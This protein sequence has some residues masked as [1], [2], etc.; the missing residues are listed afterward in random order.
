MQFEAKEKYTIQDLLQIITIL[1]SPE[2]CPWDREQTHESIRT[3]LIEE[4]YEVAD[5]IDQKDAHLLQEELGDLLLQILLHTEMERECSRFDFDDVCNTL[6]Q[7]LVYRHPHVF[8]QVEAN[9]TGQVLRNWEALKNQ[10]KGRRTA[11][12]RL[13]SVPAALPALMRSEKTQKRAAA[14]GF[15][16]VDTAAALEDLAS[17]V[18]ELREAI[19][20]G[21][22]IQHEA[23]D[24][25]FAAVN[26][27]RHAGV[28]AE[29]ALT[30][31]CQRFAGRVKTA[32]KLAQQNGEKL[33]EVSQQ[34]LDA[35]WKEAKRL[36]KSTM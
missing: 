21:Q 6:C 28:D 2:G 27:A 24:V 33:E 29:E 7:K 9:S 13:D 22:G 26:V 15:D 12:D 36:E 14:Y 23:G 25:V 32:E 10:E 30:R 8:G 1:R 35:L 34:G 4:T 18:E 31:S 3:N 16:Y 17:E 5:A 11:A 20:T 19:A